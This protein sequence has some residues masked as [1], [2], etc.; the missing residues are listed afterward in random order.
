MS[1]A[2]TNSIGVEAFSGL[3]MNRFLIHWLGVRT[4]GGANAPWLRQH[5]GGT[6]QPPPI[7]AVPKMLSRFSSFFPA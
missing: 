1:S 5:A 2:A 4:F 6:S 7:A 3:V